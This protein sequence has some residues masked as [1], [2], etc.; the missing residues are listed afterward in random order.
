MSSNVSSDKN[1]GANSSVN[2]CTIVILGATGDL[3]KRKLIP[4]IYSIISH[5]KLEKFALVGAAI[6]E[7]DM[8]EILQ[9]SKAFIENCD[10]CVWEKLKQNAY[11]QKLDFNK[12][13]DFDALNLFVSKLEEDNSLLSNRLVYLAS[14]PEF[15][16]VITKNCA[17]SGLVKKIKEDENN[18]FWQRIIYE[19]PFGRDL[20]SAREINACIEKYFYEEQIYRVDHYLTKEIIGNIALVRFTNCVFEPLWSNKYIDQVDIILDEKLCIEGRGKYYDKYGAVRDVVQNHMLE[21]LALVAMEAPKMLTGDF[22]RD[23]RVKVLQKIE[24]VDGIF[25][26]YIG[27]KQEEHINPNS[28]TETACSL[29]L[30][31]NNPR[32]QGV[33]FYLKTGKCLKAKK[34]EIKIKFKKIDCL[35]LKGCPIKSN[36]L[37]IGIYPKGTFY[38]SLN[39]KKPGM[40]NEIMPVEMEFCHSCLFKEISPESYEVIIQET[41]QGERSISVRFDEIEDLWKI[42]DKIYAMLAPLYEYKKGSCGPKETRA[43]EAKHGLGE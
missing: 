12:Q 6:D 19:K 10:E 9:E 4:A 16:C 26:Q 5:E 29:V 20:E 24:V 1:S 17:E 14:M 41:I 3:A 36:C 32:W 27:Y 21:L 23:E 43:F 22:I 8:G 2:N 38:L 33:P 18:N 40:I 28:K 31:V 39:A 11:Y 25:G 7:A 13:E 15:F 35:L 42:T 37:T 34:T 30:R